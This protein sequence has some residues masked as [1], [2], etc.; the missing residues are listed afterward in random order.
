MSG[1]PRQVRVFLWLKRENL[2]LLPA[3]V[4]GD[5]EGIFFA[6]LDSTLVSDR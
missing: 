3:K 6:G 2:V 4:L 5:G 1:R